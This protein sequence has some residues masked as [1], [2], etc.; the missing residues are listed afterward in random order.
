MMAARI[1]L[2]AVVVMPVKFKLVEMEVVQSAEPVLILMWLANIIRP[3]LLIADAP[4]RPATDRKSA[5][6][7]RLPAIQIGAQINITALVFLLV[8]FLV[9]AEPATVIFIVMVVADAPV[10][11]AM[12]AGVI[13]ISDPDHVIPLAAVMEGV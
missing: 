2:V 7:Q 13:F 1:I 8:V 10:K 4:A 6:V 12:L 11:A 3:V 9:P 5:L